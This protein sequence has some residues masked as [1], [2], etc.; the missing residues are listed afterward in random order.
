ML[1]LSHGRKCKREGGTTERPECWVWGPEARRWAQ[2]LPPPCCVTSA[3]P[4][5]VQWESWSNSDVNPGPLC[6]PGLLWESNETMSVKRALEMAECSTNVSSYDS[7]L[8]LLESL[9]H[10]IDGMYS[11][12]LPLSDQK[13]LPF[14]S[15]RGTS[16]LT[17]SNEVTK[18]PL[19]QLY[20]PALREACSL[21][22]R[23]TSFWGEVSHRCLNFIMQVS[24]QAE[25]KSAKEQVS[26][27]N[28]RG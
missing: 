12:R 8:L 23:A 7:A 20:A 26:I 17:R 16:D 18:L 11:P 2:F 15:E 13:C 1:G 27:W 28:V 14:S 9:F 24:R 10:F 25:G 22:V 5:K 3:L 4:W 19:T 6:L 21:P